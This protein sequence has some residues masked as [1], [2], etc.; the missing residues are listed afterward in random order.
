[1]ARADTRDASFV[2]SASDFLV[3][4][5]S[6]D[7]VCAP[8]TYAVSFETGLGPG[9]AS[10]CITFY[11]CGRWQKACG[12]CVRSAFHC[13][14]AL[15]VGGCHASGLCLPAVPPVTLDVFRVK[16]VTPSGSRNVDRR[17][18]ATVFRCGQAAHVMVHLEGQ[19]VVFEKFPAVANS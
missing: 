8:G 11:T 5:A 6:G 12:H 14:A 3:A 15:A 2:L 1:M 17:A 19:Q 10:V 13:T 18:C 7:L 4:T 9:A 16:L